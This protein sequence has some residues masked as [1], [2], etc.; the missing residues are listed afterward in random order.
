MAGKG[1]G[2]W[3]VAYADFVTAMMA[4]FMV[5]WLMAQDQKI[6]KAVAYYFSDPLGASKT[7]GKTGA[8]TDNAANGAIPE[9]EKVAMGNG[10]HAFAQPHG[11]RAVG[12]A[13]VDGSRRAAALPPLLDDRR[14]PVGR[15]IPGRRSV[16]P[17][18]V[19]LAGV[20]R[21]RHHHAGAPRVARH[22]RPA[23]A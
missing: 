7:P 9:S 6:K 21:R 8:V 11:R 23:V 13:Q 14:R 1:G 10:R 16:Q 20:S 22:E 2:A 17:R 4:F 15:Q 12:G 3:K 18:E 19:A 5:M